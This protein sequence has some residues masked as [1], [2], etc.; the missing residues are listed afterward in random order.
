MLETAAACCSYQQNH[1]P[2]SY[3]R[4][5]ILVLLGL[6]CAMSVSA[7]PT[8]SLVGAEIAALLTRLETSGCEFNRNGVWYNAAEAKAHLVF[9]LGFA[10]SLQST[11]QFI[12]RLAT[13]SS[14]PGEPYLVRVN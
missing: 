4:R 2:E 9:K 14:M 12:E 1:V 3:M 7:A 8:P 11:E 13:K 5:S 6:L 10:G